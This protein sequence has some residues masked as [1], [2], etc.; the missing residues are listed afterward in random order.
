MHSIPCFCVDMGSNISEN[1]DFSIDQTWDGYQVDCRWSDLDEAFTK[2]CEATCE[3]TSA[4]VDETETKVN[5]P[6]NLSTKSSEA[7]SGESTT[8]VVLTAD[9]VILSVLPMYLFYHAGSLL[10]RQRKSW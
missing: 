6:E 3:V 7:I 1:Y 4:H 8:A 9:A 5:I 2:V 10:Y